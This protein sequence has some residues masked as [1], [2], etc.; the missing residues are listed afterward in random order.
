MKITKLGIKDI[1]CR[2]LQTSSTFFVF[3]EKKGHTLQFSDKFILDWE[4][5]NKDSMVDVLTARMF[6]S[7]LNTPVDDVKCR[8]MSGPELGEVVFFKIKHS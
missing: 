6:L 3:F 7:N 8:T 4:I 2:S 1:M 5:K